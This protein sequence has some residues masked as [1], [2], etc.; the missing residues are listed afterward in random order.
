M[1]D[2]SLRALCQ[3]DIPHVVNYWFNKTDAE[4]FQAGVDKNKMGTREAWAEMLENILHTPLENA[5][6]WYL[7]WQINNQPIGYSTLRNISKNNLAD[8]HLHIWESSTRGKGY[9]ARLFAMSVVEFYK[10]FNFKLMLCEPNA[11][12][13]SPNKVL[14]K[15]GF[16][17][18]RSMLGAPVSICL[19]YEMNSYII[20][21]DT[22]LN[23]LSKSK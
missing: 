2:L 14:R 5:H 21:L 20:D 11:Q 23:Y 6:S 4:L 16:Q 22:A 10:L 3:E 12:N 9:G 13:P 19:S 1:A 15:I 8:I 18:W 17:K 7:I